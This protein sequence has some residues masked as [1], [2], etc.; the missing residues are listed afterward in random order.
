M[1]YFL[2]SLFRT[3]AFVDR[4]TRM[5]LFR[6]KCRNP[7]ETQ[8][9]YLHRLLQK[10][11]ETGFGKKYD[12]RSI[13]NIQDFQER[14][15]IHSWE[16]VSP[17]V[18]EVKKG[19]TKVLFPPSEKIIMFAQTSGTTGQPKLI[20]ITTTAY[21]LYRKYWDHTWA[22]V[23]LEYPWTPDG[24][25]LYFPGDPKEGFVGDIPFGA[26][27]AK[28]YT[29]QG[30]LKRTLYPYPISISRIKDYDLRYYTAMRIAVEKQV[31][32]I[33]IANPS[34]VITLFR[35]GHERAHEIIEDIE[36][37]RL[38]DAEKMPEDFRTHMLKYLRP[39]PKRAAELR[40]ILE[41]TGDFLP[42][43]YWKNPV[44][45][46][47]FASGPLRLYLNQLNNFLGDYYLFDFGLLASEGRFTFPIA[48][49]KRQPGC[50]L[51]LESNFFEFI[52]EDEID[53][54]NP[55][56]LTTD[57]CELGKRYYIIITNYSG[58]YR[59]NISD[60]VE[61]T[62][63]YEKVPLIT[64]S[65]KGKHFSN[66]TGEK[67]TE[68]QVTESV[69][70]AGE[71]VG[72]PL[73]DFVVCLHW[74]DRMPSYSL[75]KASNG[76]DKLGLLQ[77]FIGTVDQELMTLNVEYRSKRESR[78][79]G[80]LTLKIVADDAYQKYVEERKKSASHLAQ[81]KHTFLVSDPEFEGQF[82]FSTEIASAADFPVTSGKTE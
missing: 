4:Q 31:A 27:T 13:R 3:K 64:F 68:Y 24:K 28:A 50:C 16:H 57:Q 77:E 36:I 32:A 35:T 25:A 43:D 80:P 9:A 47:C 38:R 62:G 8:W 45:V 14:I 49:L 30:F 63:F 26:I 48:S 15:P 41:K 70:I 40:R 75:L 18:D 11:Q 60:V 39:N 56:V 23:A 78:R 61:V 1:S 21:Q 52:P 6:M 29:Q 76:K 12:F 10:H 44:S 59:Y 65:H 72:Y 7:M 81:F 51:T 82:K 17:Y 34:S 71:K 2:T 58:L 37:G 54:L 69:R 66:I 33:P 53:N 79:L 67:L 73:E 5:R 19:D 42:R 55:K 74:D 20:P 46:I 22:Q